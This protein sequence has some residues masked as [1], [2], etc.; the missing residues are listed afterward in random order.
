MA[1]SVNA[2]RLIA[3]AAARRARRG[4]AAGARSTVPG[5]RVGLDSAA[6]GGRR[7]GRA[8]AGDPRTV[9]VAQQLDD[10]EHSQR[11][12]RITLLVGVS[13]CCSPCWR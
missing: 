7:A 10:V 8:P 6:A 2:D 11:V 9:L 5:S 4:A 12:L 13:R 3:A 1:A